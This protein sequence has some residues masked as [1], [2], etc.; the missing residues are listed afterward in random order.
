[1]TL[2]THDPVVFAPVAVLTVGGL[3]DCCCRTTRMVQRSRRFHLVSPAEMVAA[4]AKICRIRDLIPP[5][6]G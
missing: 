6:G 1:L 3:R 4:V 5:T 2:D